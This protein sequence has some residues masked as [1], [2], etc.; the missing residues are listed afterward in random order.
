[1][2]F[3]VEIAPRAFRD[4]DEIADYI[5]ER[6]SF[7][8][9][10]RWFNGLMKE[11]R[12]LQDMPK[13]CARAE[14]SNETGSEIRVLSHGSGNHRYQ[15][16]FAIREQSKTVRVLHVRHWAR[17]RVDAGELEDLLKGGDR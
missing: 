4:I 12:S 15:V 17:K 9:A 11:I 3:R 16:Y 7:E 6:G 2:A 10:E 8:S 5:S 14:E 1:M 13:R